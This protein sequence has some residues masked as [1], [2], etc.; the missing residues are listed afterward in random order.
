[1]C[2]H[3]PAPPSGAK[4]CGP[5]TRRKGQKPDGLRDSALLQLREEIAQTGKDINARGGTLHDR[6]QMR[7]IAPRHMQVEAR[8]EMESCSP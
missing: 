7:V 1:M 3:V 8:G 6:N 2:G 4:I 5:G